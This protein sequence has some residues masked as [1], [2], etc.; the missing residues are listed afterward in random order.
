MFFV[1]SVRKEGGGISVESVGVFDL[2][3]AVHTFWS[4]LGLYQTPSPSWQGCYLVSSLLAPTLSFRF[5]SVGGHATSQRPREI[6][7]KLPNDN[8]Q[9]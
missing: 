1:S 2:A 7:T 6:A 5:L 9:R 4:G 8:L 3:S